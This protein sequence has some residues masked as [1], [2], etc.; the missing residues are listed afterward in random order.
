MSEMVIVMFDTNI[1][2]LII[3]NQIDV[4]SLK[5]P[6]TVFIATHIQIDEIMKT[7][8]EERRDYLISVFR[9]LLNDGS[10]DEVFL[11]NGATLNA[12]KRQIRSTESAV[13]GH[14][15]WGMAKWTRKDSL[16]ESIKL[17][18]DKLNN[19]KQNNIEDALITETCIKN[20]FVLVTEDRDLYNVAKQV[21]CLT[22]SFKDFRDRK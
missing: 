22:Q 15:R 6:N 1:F 2:N 19:Q 11:F 9:E 14:S 16:Y 4:H 10:P 5:D 8:N 21:G 7:P 13:W 12:N 20:S 3:D 17:K 18:L